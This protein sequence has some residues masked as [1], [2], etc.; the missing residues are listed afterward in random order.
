MINVDR[1]L[2]ESGLDA[3][4]IMQVHDEL[5]IEAKEECASEAAELL[6]REMENAVRLSVPLTADC[7]V[8]K[9]WYDAK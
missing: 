8:G 5:I 1:A 6:V 3:R 2:K 4:L 7:G 9:N